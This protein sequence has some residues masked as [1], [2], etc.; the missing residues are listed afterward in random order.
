M[1]AGFGSHDL[2]AG[3]SGHPEA[4][5]GL[6]Q[7]AHR[8]LKPLWPATASSKNSIVLGKWSTIYSCFASHTRATNEAPQHSGNCIPVDAAGFINNWQEIEMPQDGT[9]LRVRTLDANTTL[10]AFGHENI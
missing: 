7:E 1:P 8:H 4:R 9:K 5:V 2:L 3:G 6:A 10:S